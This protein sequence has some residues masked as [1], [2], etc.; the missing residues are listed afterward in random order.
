ML[1]LI[2]FFGMAVSLVRAAA[3]PLAD[4]DMMIEQPDNYKIFA[5]RCAV[6]DFV[7]ALAYYQDDQN[8]AAARDK[9]FRTG[10]YW[11][12]HY[13]KLGEYLGQMPALV[14]VLNNQDI[15]EETVLHR[16]ARHNDLD[17][18]NTIVNVLQ[19]RYPLNWNE[20][21]SQALGIG[22]RAGDRPLHCAAHAVA[23]AIAQ[24][25]IEFGANT[26]TT[27][28]YH[29]TPKQVLEI[30]II[31]P[32]EQL[33]QQALQNGHVFSHADEQF[34]LAAQALAHILNPP[35]LPGVVG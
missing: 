19:E 20:R 35:L 3:D 8:V 16:I 26:G 28:K 21:M 24:R 10:L 22:N 15:A 5:E 1:K 2:F 31:H 14:D 13:K 18:L 27:N 7:S 9:T 32:L 30:R 34:L 17:A 12:I 4:F 6:G 33:R 29:R 25:M 11:L 23:T